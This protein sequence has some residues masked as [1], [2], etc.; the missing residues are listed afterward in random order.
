MPVLWGFGW[1]SRRLLVLQRRHCLAYRGG[2]DSKTRPQ[3]RQ[4]SQSVVGSWPTF[5]FWPP[6]RGWNLSA[7]QWWTGISSGWTN[8]LPGRWPRRCCHQS[9]TRSCWSTLL[10]RKRAARS[11]LVVEAV[12]LWLYVYSS[13]YA[14]HLNLDVTG[15]AGFPGRIV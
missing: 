7:N 14:H 8:L 5:A 1:G 15:L 4:G 11:A 10:L 2:D 6:S 12:R 3:R 13:Q 9:S